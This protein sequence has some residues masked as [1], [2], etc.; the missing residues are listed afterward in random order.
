MGKPDPPVEKTPTISGYSTKH[1]RWL[2]Y[3]TDETEAIHCGNPG[4]KGKPQLL[5]V[6]RINDYRH[7]A[8]DGNAVFEGKP[9]MSGKMWTPHD[10]LYTTVG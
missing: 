2:V 10:T 3:N 6:N 9:W 5:T 7:G 4:F 1:Q 8:T